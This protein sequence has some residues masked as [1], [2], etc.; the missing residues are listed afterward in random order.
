MLPCEGIFLSITMEC[1]KYLFA[2]T[3]DLWFKDAAN[4]IE[5]L[6]LDHAHC[7]RKAASFALTML[8]R[9]PH[10]PDFVLKMANLAREELLHFEQV[11]K[12]IK[13]YG[14]VFQALQAGSYAAALHAKIAKQEP[15]R[16][17]DFCIVAALIEARSSERLWGLVPYLPED[18]AKYYQRLA[19][20]EDRHF[21]DY[22]EFAK[23]HSQGLDFPVKLRMWQELE[24]AQILKQD[25]VFRFHSGPLSL[26][27][28]LHAE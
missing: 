7:E 17:V 11:L 20:A 4:N 1:Q 24:S 10:Y 12:Y 26:E 21:L 15:E 5:L 27:K 22:L 19:K 8:Q 23:E 25:S 28:A 18:L 9:Y 2:A 13:K 16:M 14:F 6:L 3:S